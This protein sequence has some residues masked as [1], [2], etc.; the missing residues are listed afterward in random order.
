MYNQW[1]TTNWKSRFIL[2]ISI[3]RTCVSICILLC[4]SRVVWILAKLLTHFARNKD[5]FSDSMVQWSW[6]LA[7]C[8]GGSHDVGSNLGMAIFIFFVHFFSVCFVLFFIVLFSL[9]CFPL[10]SL[11]ALNSLVTFLWYSCGLCTLAFK[12]IWVWPCFDTKLLCFVME[13]FLEKY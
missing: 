10:F 3:K 11:Q 4:D 13:I 5:L 1:Q 9:A 7:C 2:N 6:E 12:W 8:A